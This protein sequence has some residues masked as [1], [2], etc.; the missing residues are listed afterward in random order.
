MFRLA[1]LAY[2]CH[3]RQL[4]LKSMNVGELWFLLDEFATCHPDI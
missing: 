1:I 2:K 4:L 3:K